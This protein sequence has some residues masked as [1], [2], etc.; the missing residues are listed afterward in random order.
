MIQE[1][2]VH[3]FLSFK[4]KQTISFVASADKSMADELIIEP[5]PGV[6]LL[7]M[8]MIYG[9]NASGK[10][11]LLRSMHTMWKLLIT[12]KVNAND[13]V[14]SYTPFELTKNE[15][16]IFEM[17]FW[18]NNRRY[19]YHLEYDSSSILY[20][21]LEYTTDSGVLSLM[22]ERQKGSEIK[23]GGTIG[24][25]AKQRNEF[26][27]ET[28]V[29][30]TVLS[31]LTKKNIDA[32]III[33]ELYD[34]ISLN[35]FEQK[36]NAGVRNIAEQA[37]GNKKLKSMIIDLLCKADLNITDFNM[38]D[39]SLPD[40]VASDI[41]ENETI[42]YELKEQL[43]KYRKQL[44]FT[45]SNESEEFQISYDSESEGTK[46]YFRLARVL[47]NLQDSECVIMEDELDSSLH[48][49]L[50]LH[51]LQTYLQMT[52]NSQLIFT[53]HNQ[54]LM[55]EDWMI[56]RDMVWFVEKD[57]KTASSSLYRASDLGLH[58]NVSL[59]NAYRIGK[60]GAK[61]ILGSTLLNS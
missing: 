28:L 27:L 17:T 59:M 8:S 42:N 37:E 19:A 39:F 30:H 12:P 54:L 18:A 52:T 9:A 41:I 56:R 4:D 58:K 6:K 43:L 50:L 57:R 55:D 26:N 31:T 49:D 47:F 3:N 53:T 21:K 16:I 36:A 15:P 29:N 7:R 23:F 5:Q 22:Y 45:H 10:S 46:A 61:P 33:K 40:K 24:I 51:Y 48:Y 60:I 13:K 2:S 20:E 14:I 44:V 34:W 25:K 38:I 1:F 32:P 11:N 35:Y